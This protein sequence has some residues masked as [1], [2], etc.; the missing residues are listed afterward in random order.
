MGTACGISILLI[1]S[2][3]GYHLL[4]MSS[5]SSG[6]HEVIT[7]GTTSTPTTS[8]IGP[9]GPTTTT[10]PL[11]ALAEGTKFE[12]LWVCENSDT[13]FHITVDSWPGAR[14]LYKDPRADC[15]GEYYMT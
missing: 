3:A 7:N 5:G 13:V 1:I 15:D 6:G 14:L 2:V 4:S 8:T 11:T 12:G 9:T 10:L